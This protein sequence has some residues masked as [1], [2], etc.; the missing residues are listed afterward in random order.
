MRRIFIVALMLT[1]GLVLGQDKKEDLNFTPEQH[2]TLKT[3]KMILNLDL[4]DSQQK[5]VYDLNLATAKEHEQNKKIKK[6]L[7]KIT[8][9]DK[10][11]LMNAKLD[12]QIKYR[13][14]L[15]LILSPEQLEKFDKSMSMS[16]M[17]YKKQKSHLKKQR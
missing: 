6:D 15:L 11:N 14:Q 5:R 3:K 13:K 10:Y 9:E 12:S 1:S 7:D 16:K 17:K 8:A 2:A 4:N